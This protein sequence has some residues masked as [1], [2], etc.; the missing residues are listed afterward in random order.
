MSIAPNIKIDAALAVVAHSDDCE[1]ACGG[2][3]AKW[4]AQGVRVELVVVTDGAAGSHDPE[5]SDIV[6]AE[7]RRAE[8]LEAASILG[9]SKVH[10]L[11]EP[12]G[13]VVRSDALVKQLV[14][15]VRQVRPTV[16][17]AHDPWRPYELHPDH[18]AAGWLAVDASWHAKEP[19]FYTSQ[20]S[21]NLSAWRPSELWLLFTNEPNYVED[22]TGA[23]D[24]KA[25]A[26]LTYRSQYANAFGI[27]PGDEDS[28][29]IFEASIRTRAAEIGGPAGYDFG[30]DFRRLK[31]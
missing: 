8:Q 6:L 4:T 25:R 11:D 13:A 17:L 16:V 21:F 23:I 15:I 14:R 3:I 29:G 24:V 30:E 5:I 9:I 12:D 19:R 26:L 31:L 2:T 7:T 28:V 18:R 27:L 10:F 1:E 22:V 20:G